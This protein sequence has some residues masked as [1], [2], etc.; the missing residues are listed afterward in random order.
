MI[1]PLLLA[2]L[3]AM[4]LVGCN[5]RTSAPAAGLAFDSVSLRRDA[6]FGHCPVYNVEVKADGTI[7]FTGKEYVKSL[8]PQRGT[9]S[10]DGLALLS[11]AVQ[12]ADLPA[13]RPRYLEESDGCKS[14]ATDLP[15]LTITVTRAGATRTVMFYHGC[16]GMGALATRLGWLAD[17]IDEI[18]GT[19]Q[20]IGYPAP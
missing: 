20:W 19:G 12:H 18:A 7:S 2:A 3:T 6:C 10:K 9:V 13:M 1:K 15:S 4:L 8:G 5:A 11:L 14:V 17:T 16:F